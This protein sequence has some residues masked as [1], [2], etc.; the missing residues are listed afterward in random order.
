MHLFY[1]NRLIRAFLGA[2]NR[3]R[4]AQPFTGFDPADDLPLST[5]SP[6]VR[7]DGRH[8][9]GPFPLLNIALNLV[10]GEELAWQER[11][12]ASFV[13]TPLFSG[14][15]VHDDENADPGLQREGYRPTRGYRQI[16]DQGISLGTAMTISGAAA[17][18]NM[19]AGTTPAMSFLLTVFNVRLGWWLGNPRHGRTWDRMGP[20]VGI[21]ALLAELFGATDDRS[22]YV[23]LSDGGHFDNLGLY[24]LIRRR[25][26]LVVVSDAGADP[27]FTFEDLGNAVRKC[28]T[29]FGVEIEIG[30]DRIRRVPETGLSRAQWCSLPTRNGSA[31]P[32][33]PNHP[34]T[35]GSRR[36]CSGPGTCAGCICT[37]PGCL[38]P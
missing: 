12:A 4:K 13:F 21:T 32:G 6:D 19:G 33:R 7:R 26:R 9:D 11:R 10:S 3:N 22:R 14:F 24:E 5:L 18:P 23:Y 17:S 29:D 8:Y 37:K 31:T 20:R 35:A 30:P 38:N 27:N 25:C 2:S 34:T 28:C 36:C 1:R 16:P 15:Q